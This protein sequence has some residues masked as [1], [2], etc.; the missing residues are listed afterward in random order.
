MPIAEV[1]YHLPTRTFNENEY[2]S[3]ITSATQLARGLSEG[4]LEPLV[5]A[6]EE[7]A[8]YSARLHSPFMLV[9]GISRPADDDLGISY[10]TFQFEIDRFAEE[11]ENLQ[12][13]AAMIRLMQNR[14]DSMISATEAQPDADVTLQ[15]DLSFDDIIRPQEHL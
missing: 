2:G 12:P 9:L 13:T 5:P 11:F 6:M 15:Q 14:R 3:I 7:R 8:S 10:E 1:T 4:S